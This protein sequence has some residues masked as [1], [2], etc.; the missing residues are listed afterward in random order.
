MFRYFT[1]VGNRRWLDVL[2][3]LVNG[4]NTSVHRSIG[5]APRDVNKR[6]E[7]QLWNKQADADSKIKLQG[8]KLLH[9]GDYVRVSRTKQIFAKG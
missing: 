6:N 4:Y 8:H 7:F 3:K 2:P 5:M 1:H 9:V